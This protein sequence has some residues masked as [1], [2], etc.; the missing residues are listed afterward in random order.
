MILKNEPCP[1]L[2]EAE[3]VFTHDDMAAQGA[4]R[5]P[6]FYRAALL[7]AQSQWRLGFPARS[8]LL[9]SRAMAADLRADDEVLG[10][11]P[12]PYSAVAWLIANRREGQFFGNPTLHFQHLASRMSG[13]NKELRSWRAWACWY[14]AKELLDPSE[15]PGD[16][17]QIRREGLVEPTRSTISHHLQSLSSLGDGRAWQDALGRFCSPPMILR[18]GSV[19]RISV[20]SAR[21]GDMT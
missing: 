12:M 5:G 14:L 17:D 10:R 1:F 8:L 7:Y 4:D 2:P 15:F 11:H 18:S 20:R 21:Q 19:R 13:P 9:C 6:S 3:R 16:W